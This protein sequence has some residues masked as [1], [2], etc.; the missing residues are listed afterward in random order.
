M[1]GRHE[2]YKSEAAAKKE[3]K[4]RGWKGLRIVP[5]V[6]TITV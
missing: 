4:R 2:T 5:A 6:I 1:D 3:L